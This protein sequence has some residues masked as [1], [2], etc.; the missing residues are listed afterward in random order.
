MR[1]ETTTMR[2][3]FAIDIKLLKWTKRS[4][5]EDA[6]FTT[7]RSHY[8]GCLPEREAE[9]FFNEA[10]KLLHDTVEAQEKS[11]GKKR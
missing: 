10:S 4:L 9:A 3:G 5:K 8:V 7:H 1:K 6:V 11:R 2:K